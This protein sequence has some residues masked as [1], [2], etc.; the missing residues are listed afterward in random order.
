M[1]VIWRDGDC[2]GEVVSVMD[3]PNVIKMRS[4]VMEECD[5]EQLVMAGTNR[6]DSIPLEEAV[7]G[8]LCIY[9]IN[10]CNVISP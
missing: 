10:K 6:R 7:P 2:P 4:M 8:N 1:P 3:G 5:K 9:I